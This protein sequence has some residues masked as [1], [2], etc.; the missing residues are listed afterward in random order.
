MKNPILNNRFWLVVGILLVVE[1]AA[2]FAFRSCPRQL[3]ESECSEVYRH[4]A[5]VEGV[6]AAFVKGFPINDTVAVDVTLL[7]ATDSAGWAFLVDTFHISKDRIKRAKVMPAYRVFE[8]QVVR[9]QP[10]TKA[11]LKGIN[12]IPNLTKDDVELCICDF[13]EN[14]ISIFHAQNAKEIDAIRNYNFDKM[15]NKKLT[16][17]EDKKN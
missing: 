3:P 15:T 11:V 8:W 9:G 10:E 12:R 7:H 1:C 14:E 6:E 17:D 4:Y 5:H 2:L 16:N 13:Q